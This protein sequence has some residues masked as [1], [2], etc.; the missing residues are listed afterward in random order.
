MNERVVALGDL[1][2]TY[3]Y[4]KF[5]S[6]IQAHGWFAENGFENVSPCIVPAKQN[7]TFCPLVSHSNILENVG[8]SRPIRSSS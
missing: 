7:Q 3:A 1:L 8:M 5:D 2:T 4:V 6:V